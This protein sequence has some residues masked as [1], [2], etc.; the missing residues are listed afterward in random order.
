MHRL[1]ASYVVEATYSP[2]AAT[3]REPFRDEHLSRLSA[4]IGA[5]SLIVAGALDDMSGSLLIATMDHEDEVLARVHDDVYWREGVWVD[6][7]LRRLN[8]LVP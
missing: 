4:D 3:R 5:G 8:R 2:D 6:V 7:R 1:E